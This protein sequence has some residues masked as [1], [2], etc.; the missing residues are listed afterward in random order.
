VCS[1]ELPTGN[2]S[3]YVCANV[4]LLQQYVKKLLARDSEL[5]IRQISSFSVL[6]AF[7]LSVKNKDAKMVG[8]RSDF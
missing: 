7:L 2:Q 5:Y 8:K 6:L 4:Y 3:Y 1:A